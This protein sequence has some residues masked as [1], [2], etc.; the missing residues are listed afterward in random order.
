MEVFKIEGAQ[1]TFVLVS[2]LQD[3]EF[4]QKHLQELTSKIFIKNLCHEALDSPVDGYILLP[5][6]SPQTNP[7]YDF[8]WKFYNSDGS[9][10]EM[11]GNAARAVSWWYHENVQAK[12]DIKFLA[13]KIPVQAEVMTSERVEVGLKKVESLG[14]T[15]TGHYLYNSGVPHVVVFIPDDPEIFVPGQIDF[16]GSKSWQDLAKA[17]RFPAELDQAGANVTLI[18][19]SPEIQK[20]YAVTYER[21][22]ENWTMACGTGAMAAAY[23]AQELM[24]FAFPIEVNMPGGALIIAEQEDKTLLRGPAKVVQKKD[25]DLHKFW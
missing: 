24:G 5:P 3:P 20:V 15:Q 10:A 14:K 6:S 21:G 11:C 4:Y 2:L 16:E 7:G 9:S 18:W 19:P 12:K 1:N 13:R 17:L 22:V 23:Y 25:V 8:V